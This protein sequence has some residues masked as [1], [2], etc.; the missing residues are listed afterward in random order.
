MMV[1]CTFISLLT[2]KSPM[3]SISPRLP[4]VG[5]LSQRN[6]GQ[7]ADFASRNVKPEVRVTFVN[8][9]E[10]PTVSVSRGK[11]FEVVV[12]A[13]YRLATAD[14]AKLVSSKTVKV[15]GMV[16]RG[17]AQIPAGEVSVVTLEASKILRGGSLTFVQEANIGRGGA[18]LA[19]DTM[20][21]PLVLK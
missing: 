21:F 20:R 19:V 15:P 1:R 7:Y 8:G 9:A 5:F 12:P 2:Q 10:Q 6:F 16:G 18:P 13:G 4:S 11:R 14:G 17:G 3:S